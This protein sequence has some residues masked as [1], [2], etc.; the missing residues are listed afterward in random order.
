MNCLRKLAIVSL[1]GAVPL[2]QGETLAEIYQL[3]LENDATF[4]ASEASFL[5]DQEG[6][7]APRKNLLPSIAESASA[8]YNLGAGKSRLRQDANLVQTRTAKGIKTFSVDG[9]NYSFN[10]RNWFDFKAAKHDLERAEAQFALDQQNLIVRVVGAYL[11]VLRASEALR[12]ARS[13][14]TESKQ[15][16]QSAKERFSVGLVAITD[17]HQAQ[18]TFDN[19]V[20]AVLQAEGEFAIRFEA[21]EVLTGKR[22]FEVSALKADFPVADPE[23]L[24]RDQWVDF[25]L[26]NNNQLK[27][28]KFTQEAIVD[29]TKSSAYNYTPTVSITAGGFE[30]IDTP[31]S[32]VDFG[33]G[34]QQSP[35]R[36]SSSYRNTNVRIS[37]PI[38]TWGLN[39]SQRKVAAQQKVQAHHNYVGAR[40]QIIQNTRT[41][42]LNAK[43]NAAR[44]R[45]LAS[46]VTSAESAYKA[47]QSGY[48][49]GTQTILDVLTEQSRL[50]Q[51]QQNYA[52]ARYDY[53][54]SFMELKL[55]SGQ[56]SPEDVFTLNGW[57]DDAQNV[58]KEKG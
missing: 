28:A 9:L 58:I 53:I 22:H 21:L 2:A 55:Q 33:Q 27:V 7:V 14:E 29:R 54:L 4:K 11:D 37:V 3:A 40:R 19:A 1:L 5:I 56:L 10:V 39:Q 44:V 45:A 52:N 13:N 32:V 41:S 48:E 42:F 6:I 20:V 46:A 30:Y 51:A 47:T 26:Q 31:D 23:P 24:D 43:T 57:L 49:V 18:A 25:S 36:E 38:F 35:A 8:G 12:I 50:F 15:R 16:L 17:V 34:P